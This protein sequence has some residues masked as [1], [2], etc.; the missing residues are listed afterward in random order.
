MFADEEA[1]GVH[2]VLGTPAALRA[3]HLYNVQQFQI[4]RECRQ[5]VT[6]VCKQEIRMSSLFTARCKVQRRV[7]DERC[8]CRG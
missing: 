8:S 4:S 5:A 7:N 6:F 3:V 2:S 1:S